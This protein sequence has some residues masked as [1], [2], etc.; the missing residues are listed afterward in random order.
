DEAVFTVGSVHVGATLQTR[1]RV[2]YESGELVADGLTAR[3]DALSLRTDR[4]KSDG[5]W[6]RVRDTTLRYAEGELRVDSH[7][8]IEDAR[9]A[10]VHLTRLDPIIEAVPDLRRIQPIAVHAK[11]RVRDESLELE[12][13]DAEQLG[14]H[15]ATLWSMRGDDWRLAVLASGLTAFGYTMAA[16]QKLGRPFVLVG[17]S[18]YAEQC[19]WVRALGVRRQG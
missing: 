16:E 8:T 9:P 6:V 2:R 14:L 11:M 3:T 4:G 18:W 17:E 10:I 7:A 5:T 15:V 12:I 19:R 13:V 1:G